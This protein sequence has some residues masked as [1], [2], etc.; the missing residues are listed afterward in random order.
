MNM[1][2]VSYVNRPFK[3]TLPLPNSHEL[4]CLPKKRLAPRQC[5]EVGRTEMEIGSQVLWA[6]FHPSFSKFIVEMPTLSI[7]EWNC[8]WKRAFKEVI[9]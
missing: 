6:V 5:F 8:I 1:W 9:G 2:K 4:S 3:K 7:S